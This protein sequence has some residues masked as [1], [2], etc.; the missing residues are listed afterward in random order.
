M[1]LKIGQKAPDFKVNEEQVKENAKNRVEKRFKNYTGELVIVHYYLE[2]ERIR[3]R[4][5]TKF[6]VNNAANVRRI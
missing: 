5:R 6:R 3:K 2:K 1:T 4:S